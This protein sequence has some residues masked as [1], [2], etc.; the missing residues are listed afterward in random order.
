M[1]AVPLLSW[2]QQQDGFATNAERS[3][4]RLRL[5]SA[6]NAGQ[7]MPSVREIQDQFLKNKLGLENEISA[8]TLIKVRFFYISLNLK[9]NL[10][11][12]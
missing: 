3:L 2:H 12:N 5:S 4:H 1:E 6:V 8:A 11:Q 7:R 9:S 10:L